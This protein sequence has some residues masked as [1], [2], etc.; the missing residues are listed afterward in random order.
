MRTL[1]TLCFICLFLTSLAQKNKQSAITFGY[2]HQLPI[3]DLAD[4]FGDNS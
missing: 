4:R 3:G 2:T 1:T